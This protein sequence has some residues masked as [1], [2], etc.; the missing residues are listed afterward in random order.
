MTTRGV[1]E[2]STYRIPVIVQ[3]LPNLRYGDGDWMSQKGRQIAIGSIPVS[4]LASLFEVDRFSQDNP[5]GYQ[6]VATEARVNALKRDLEHDRVDLPTAILLNMREFNPSTHFDGLSGHPEL[7]LGKEDKLYVVDGQHRVEA[8]VRL[9]RENEKGKEKWG[10]FA[11]PFVCLLGADRDGEMNEFHVVNSNAKSIGTGLA[12]ELIK[13]RADNSAA[14]RDHLIETGRVWVQKAESLTQMLSGMGVWQNRIQFPG[15][16]QKD[17]LITNNGMTTSL[18]PLVGQPGYF[19]SIG[20]TE[21][22]AKVLNSYWEGIKIVLP[23]VMYDPE[24]F[25]IQRTLGATALH[26]VLVNVLAVMSSKGLSV[27]DPHSFAQVIETPLKDLSETNQNGETVQGADF[28]KRGAEGASGLFSGRAGAR[29]LQA[30][31]AEKLPSVSVQ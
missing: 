1:T 4:A 8:L 11:I 5:E 31:I 28:W 6:R 16:K 15:P 26:A 23:G 18:R 3:D 17:T 24:R 21:Q 13:R 22:Q 27:L 30:R 7:V 20:E 10:K 9:Y 29:I 14:V 19:Q 25:N 2:A 12:Y